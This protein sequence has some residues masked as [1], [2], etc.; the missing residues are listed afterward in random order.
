MPNLNSETYEKFFKGLFVGGTGRGK[1]IAASSWPGK[2][3][4]LDFDGRHKPIIDWYPERVKA[5]DF[6]AEIITPENFWT[7][8][9]PLVNNIV[10]YNPYQNVILDGI[11]TLSTTTI[12]MQ[13]M[14]KGS[15]ANWF[16]KK[17]E[18]MKITSGG[19]AVPGWDEMNGE[20]MIISTLL[21]TLKSLKCNLFITAHPVTRTAINANKKA[22]RYYSITTFGPKVE[23]IIPTYFDEVFYFDYK[24]DIDNMGKEIIKRTCYTGPSEDYFEAKCSLKMPKEIDYTNKNLYDCVKDYL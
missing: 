5:G 17:E 13:M 4:I 12:V 1:T 16:G 9:K 22:T 14:A 6:T 21:E 8:F 11:T 15:F 18:G 10:K 19:I 23:S 20:T 2:T 3:L 7:H 24:V